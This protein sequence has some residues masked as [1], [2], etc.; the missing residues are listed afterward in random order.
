MNEPP[1]NIPA[2]NRPILPDAQLSP[3]EDRLT[4]DKWTDYKR[5]MQVRVAFSAHA[6]CRWSMSRRTLRAFRVSVL[7]CYME[8]AEGSEWELCDSLDRGVSPLIAIDPLTPGVKTAVHWTF[9]SFLAISVFQWQVIPSHTYNADYRE[10]CRSARAR[11]LA[12]MRALQARFKHVSELK[13][14]K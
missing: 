8:S 12:S 5:A 2:G 1:L 13:E 3:E 10:S 11:E 9:A 4:G 14:P 7:H 6:D